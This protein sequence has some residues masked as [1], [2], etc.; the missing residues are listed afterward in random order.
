MENS[1]VHENYLPISVHISNHH[2][3]KDDDFTISII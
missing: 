2:V 1:K 3:T